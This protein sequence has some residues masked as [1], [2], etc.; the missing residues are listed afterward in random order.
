MTVE[1]VIDAGSQQKPASLSPTTSRRRTGCL[2]RRPGWLIEQQAQTSK[3]LSGRH[4]CLAQFMLCNPQRASLKIATEGRVMMMN[5]TKLQQ[6][7]T[8]MLRKKRHHARRQAGILSGQLLKNQN[9]LFAATPGVSRNNRQ[10]GFTPAYLDLNSGT[11]MPSRYADGRPAP[12]HLLDGLPET[13]VTQRDN[14]GHVTQARRGV[15]AGFLR[16]G[17]FYTREQAVRALSH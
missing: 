10:A 1:N 17:Q 16:N 13:W 5:N 12:I 7:S 8:E 9:S 6:V 3:R 15:I 2:S 4:F 14:A 11:V